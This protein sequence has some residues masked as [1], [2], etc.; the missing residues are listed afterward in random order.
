MGMNDENEI[1][2]LACEGICGKS[3]EGTYKEL[4]G[5]IPNLSLLPNFVCKCGGDISLDI[6]GRYK[7][8]SPTVGFKPDMAYPQYKDNYGNHIIISTD[9]W[10]QLQNYV[11]KLSS[12]TFHGAN[13]VVKKHWA[14]ILAG[15]IPFGMRI[16]KEEEQNEEEKKK[17]KEG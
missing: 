4:F 6:T 2:R 10:I 5:G 14:D 1:I 17:S 12:E 15:I 7:I 13:I 8:V 9:G 16:A 11:L 3:I